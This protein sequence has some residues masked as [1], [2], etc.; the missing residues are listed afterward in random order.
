MQKFLKEM[1]IAFITFYRRRISPLK[2]P[3]CRFYPS[4]SYYALQAVHKYG[5]CK[6][7][8]LTVKRLC[9]CHPFHRGGYD[10]LP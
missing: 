10:P 5:L 6:G 9:R 4:C 2:P 1:L 7:L 8:F 3:A